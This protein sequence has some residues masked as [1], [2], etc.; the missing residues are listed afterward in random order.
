MTSA[1]SRNFHLSARRYQEEKVKAEPKKAESTESAA[2]QQSKAGNAEDKPESESS[3]KA[4]NEE[5]NKKDGEEEGKDKEGQEKKEDAPPPPPHGDKTPWQVFTETMS[6]EFQKSKEWNESTKQIGAAAHQ[7]SESDSVRR[8]REAYEKSTGAVSSTA[9]AAFKGT[10][11]AIGKGAAW[12]WDTSVVKGARKA[13]NATGETLDKATKP[14]RDTEAY[15]NVKN[16][17]DDG[18]SSRYGGWT[19]KEERRKR[20]EQREKELGNSGK[21][22][23]ED[24]E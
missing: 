14:L 5:E 23:V 13:A 1:Q 6:T 19:E 8:A 16:V 18:S 20:R 7:F 17:I 9:S 24:P 10:A 2:E 21:V 15:K 22:M 4:E 12:T 3:K 11:G